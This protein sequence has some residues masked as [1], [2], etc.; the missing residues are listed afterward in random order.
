MKLEFNLGF[1]HYWHFTNERQKAFINKCITSKIKTSDVVINKYKFTNT[2][3]CLDRTSQ[4]LIKNIINLDNQDPHNLFFR[5]MIFKL[6]NKISTWE[7]LEKRL[8]E[9]NI[10]DFSVTSFSEILE[11]IKEKQ[12][13]YSN[14]YIVPS[15]IKEYGRELKHE[16]NLLML[17]FMLDNN[18]QDKIW[19]LKNLEDIFNLFISVPTLGPFLAYQY[20][21]DIAL[22]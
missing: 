21:I 15:G 16:N 6:F 7:L 3:R 2:Y 1:D 19:E 18:F 4:F 20:A 17:K 13:I 8:G 22:I 11:K 5:I 14:A 10:K 9:I 12:A